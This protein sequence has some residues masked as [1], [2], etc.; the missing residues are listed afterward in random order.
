MKYLFVKLTALTGMILLAGCVEETYTSSNTGGYYS[1][2]GSANYYSVPSRHQHRYPYPTNS[3]GYHSS[4]GYS[5]P[6]S[7]PVN[8]GYNASPTSRGYHSSS[9]PV[10]SNGGYSSSGA[11][12]GNAIQ[13]ASAQGYGSSS[14]QQQPANSGPV[15]SSGGY[16]AAPSASSVVTVGNNNPTPAAVNVEK[17]DDG[18]ASSAT[19]GPSVSAPVAVNTPDATNAGTGGYS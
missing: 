5:Q 6:P 2:S 4:S 18:Y 7:G 1:S 19:A 16:S 9:S 8:G 13:S 10:V 12:F 17:K 11:R 3:G 15:A 14:S